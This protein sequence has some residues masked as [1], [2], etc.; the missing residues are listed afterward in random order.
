MSDYYNVLGIDRNATSDDVKKAYH[1]LAMKWH[2]DK[3]AGNKEAE[4][5]FK[6]INE[7]YNT[8]SDDVKRQQYD[9][10]GNTR[11]NHQ[12]PQHHQQRRAHFPGDDI[13]SQMFSQA[14]NRTYQFNEHQVGEDIQIQLTVTLEDVLNGPEK[15]VNVPILEN[16]PTCDGKGSN[17][18]PVRC[19]QCNGSG[20]IMF[21]HG[22]MQMSQTCPN[23]NGRGN[24]YANDCPKCHGQKK[25]KKNKTTSVRI[26]KG[27]DSNT[28]I[29]V[30]GAGNPGKINGN[31]FVIIDVEKHKSFHR[32]NNNLLC[33][34]DIDFIQAILGG[35]VYI[36][37]LSGEEIKLDI[38]SGTQNN[39][40]IHI[41]GKGLPSLHNNNIIGDLI[42]SVN[43]TIPKN[44]N[45][46]QRNILE[47][48]KSI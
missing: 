29:E 35:E 8:L 2:P 31:L 24:V 6:E 39:T 44:I 36:R 27:I 3:N 5:K 42:V 25:F 1:K 41:K 26:P 18:P 30:K 12:Q 40:K 23:C 38:Q 14:F 37:T 28:R 48:W 17:K 16:C 15:L 22:P 43:V 32:E 7:A 20:Q 10:F 4:N 11:Q 33:Y 13:F 19:G 47:N 34:V 45:E 46:K 21:R 9:M